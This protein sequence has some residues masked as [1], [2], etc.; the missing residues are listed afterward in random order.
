MV[1]EVLLMNKFLKK[2]ENFG[3][4]STTVRVIQLFILIMSLLPLFLSWKCSLKSG[5]TVD[6]NILK[7]I[8]NAFFSFLYGTFYLISYYLK[9]GCCHV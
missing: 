8:I 3:Q 2:K 6:K 5:L 4:V 9:I 7:M 1:F